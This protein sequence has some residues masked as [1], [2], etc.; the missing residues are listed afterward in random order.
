MAENWQ[1]KAVISANSTGMIKS[2]TEVAKAAKSTRKYLLDI[3]KAASNLSGRIGLPMAA[4]SGVLGGFSV[5]AVKNAVTGFAEM[6]E[7]IKK[8]S[9]KAGTSVEDYQR[10]KYVFEQAGVPV[11]SMENAMGKLNLNIGKAAN[12]GNKSLA[13][14]MA[15]LGISMRDANGDVR[16]AIDL[17]PLLA[18]KLKKNENPTR[19]S[20]MAMAMFGKTYADVLPVLLEGSKKIR[21]GME[22]F[23]TIKSPLDERTV[24]KAKDLGDEFRRFDLVVKGFQGTIA[25]ELAPI[26]GDVARATTKWWIANK[27]AVG[28]EVGKMARDLGNWIKSI[29][30]S[31]VVLGAQNFA[32]SVGNLV[33]MIGG[34]KNALIGLVIFMNLQTI[35]AFFALLGATWRL[36]AGLA[37]L[38]ARAIPAVLIAMGL[39]TP[40]TTAAAVATTGLASATEA[41]S[42]AAGGWLTRLTAVLGVLGSIAAAAAPLAIMWGVKKWSEDQSHDLERVGGIQKNMMRPAEGFLSMFGF[43]KNADIEERRRQNRAELDGGGEYN[44]WS[45]FLKQSQS[46]SLL[47]QGGQQSGGKFIFDFQNAPAGFRLKSEE[48]KGKT[49]VDMNVGYSSNSLG[50]AF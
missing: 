7:A 3:G 22:E 24:D 44:S 16:T 5:I 41:A 32:R 6:G 14:L 28:S 27:Q 4:V 21:E 34:T 40:A 42:V 11:E 1:L 49:T 38:A 9:I 10:L 29:D 12:G 8:G 2:L 31:G 35:G 43:D 23:D 20:R 46:P 45:P 25:K 18:D 19:R 50:L 48:T 33:N 36:G 13:G 37:L 47:N 30:W 17:M 15:A 39:Y 26:I